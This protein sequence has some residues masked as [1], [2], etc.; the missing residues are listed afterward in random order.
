MG[1]G[2]KQTIKL[3]NGV[4]I[5][6][7]GLGVFRV[8]DEEELRGAVKAA[9]GTGYIHIDTAAAYQNEDMVGRA[10]ADFGKREDVFITTKLINDRHEE[11]EAAFEESLEKLNTDYV[12]LYLI[13]WPNPHKGNFIKAWQSMIKFLEDGRA[14]AI[15]V[16]N[17][18]QA[19][20]DT[21]IAE[22]GVTPMV[23][24]VE[25][26]PFFQQKELADYCMA[27]GIK[28]EAYAPLTSGNLAEISELLGGVS[29][30]H[31]K[32]VAQVMLRWQLQTGWIIL[33]KSV[34]PS[35]IEENSQLFDFELDYDDMKVIAAIES[36]RR[37][38]PDSDTP[39]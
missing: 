1:E 26:H 14:R 19:H 30:K 25:R 4:E 5:P 15:G 9:L 37:Y 31:N 27:K 3:S 22:T 24:Q 7:V 11:A 12:D 32:S 23:N 28:M 17:F 21:L 10:V 38:F 33:P 34:T 8:R 2:I 6:Q 35:R 36:G 16:S 29:K 39:R 18:K 13:H 20:L